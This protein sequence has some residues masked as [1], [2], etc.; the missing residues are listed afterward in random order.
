MT[1]R[2]KEEIKEANLNKPGDH[3]IYDNIDIKWG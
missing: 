2:E 3:F 1:T